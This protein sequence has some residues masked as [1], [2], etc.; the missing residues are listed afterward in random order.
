MSHPVDQYPLS[1]QSEGTARLE[2]IKQV[3]EDTEGKIN[4][5]PGALYISIKQLRERGMIMEVKHNDDTAR[6]YYKLTDNGKQV[7]V[8]ELE[9]YQNIIDLARRRQCVNLH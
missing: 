8:S 4:L 5:G 2:I 6:R 3:K 9:H 1:T 7:L